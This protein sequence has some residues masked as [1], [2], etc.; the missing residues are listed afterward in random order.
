MTPPTWWRAS[1]PLEG[2]NPSWVLAV[3]SVSHESEPA[4]RAL[5]SP[6]SEALQ[7]SGRKRG[8]EWTRRGAG[9]LKGRRDRR[10]PRSRGGR[11]LPLQ[12]CSGA[13]KSSIK[14]GGT[15]VRF[16]AGRAETGKEGPLQ[17]ELGGGDPAERAARQ[18]GPVVRPQVT[19]G[20]TPQRGDHTHREATE[21]WNE[22]VQSL[23]ERGETTAS[24]VELSEERISL[25]RQR[26]NGTSRG[27]VRRLLGDYFAQRTG[28][29]GGPSGSPE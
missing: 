25:P 8:A 22:R 27:G 4:G 23:E 9:A 11:C 16:R 15:T 24:L 26:I 28:L 5:G 17:R 21:G 20:G 10:A 7:P 12:S 19:G 2:E 14:L 1:E 29:S 18:E 6:R 3:G 13:G